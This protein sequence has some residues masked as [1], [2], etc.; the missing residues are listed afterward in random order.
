MIAADFV[1]VQPQQ[2]VQH[3]AAREWMLQKQ[4]IDA[5]MSDGSASLTERD[6]W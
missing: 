4:F 2:V 3:A 6:S 1:A 5:S